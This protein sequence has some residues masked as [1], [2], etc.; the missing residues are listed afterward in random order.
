M[1]RLK[2][3]FILRAVHLVPE[4]SEFTYY[5][6][7]YTPIIKLS[8]ADTQ[9]GSRVLDRFDANNFMTGL[10]NSPHKFTIHVQIK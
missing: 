8:N 1:R 3:N 6:V 4:K 7:R 10:I 9:R 2:Q 5:P